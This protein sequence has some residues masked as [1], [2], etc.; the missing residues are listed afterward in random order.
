MPTHMCE[1][2][3]RKQWTSMPL[4][5]AGYDFNFETNDDIKT[6]HNAT[7]RTASSRTTRVATYRATNIVKLNQRRAKLTIISRGSDCGRE[8]AIKQRHV[9]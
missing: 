2:I 9:I 1:K 3:G 5:Y 6:S 8:Y 7:K 4:K